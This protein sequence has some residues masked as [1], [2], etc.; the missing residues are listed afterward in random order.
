MEIGSPDWEAFLLEHARQLG[1][2]LERRQAALFGIHAAELVVWNRVINL[3]R[4]LDPEEMAV[5]HFLDSIAPVPWLPSRGRLLD[6]GCGG[7][8]PGL[9]IKIMM[10]ALSVTLID[11]SR[12]KVNFV[13]HVIR[14]LAQK[15]ILAIHGRAESMMPEYGGFD[16]VVSRAT[17]D[18]ERLLQWSWPLLRSGGILLAMKG[19]KV[20]EEIRTAFWPTEIQSACRWK[21]YTY[22]LP[23]LDAERSLVRIVKV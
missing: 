3:T 20:D 12:K 11:A 19:E 17:A 14:L 15:D 5:K 6:I 4:I 10:P 21:R 23:M 18:L 9:P 1:V 8:F 13:N 7:G 2:P 22:R 16:A